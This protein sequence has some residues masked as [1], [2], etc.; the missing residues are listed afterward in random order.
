MSESDRRTVRGVD[1]DGG[2]ARLEDADNPDAWIEAEYRDGW[3]GRKLMSD[4]DEYAE[5]THPYYFRCRCCREYHET[6][7]WG[8]GSQF[9]P[10]C[11]QR[12]EFGIGPMIGRIGDGVLL[13]Q[14]DSCPEC[15][16]EDIRKGFIADYDAE[17][18]DCGHGFSA[19]PREREVTA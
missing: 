14:V 6:Q 19:K 7:R 12:W 13:Y 8:K 5:M 11:E 16:S 10:H 17:C 1:L 3:V 15:G 2:A 4:G 18:R 9:C